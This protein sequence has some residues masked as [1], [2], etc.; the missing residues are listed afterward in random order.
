MGT[1]AP[2]CRSTF[3]ESCLYAAHAYHLGDT[4]SAPLAY[5]P[6]LCAPQGSTL[7]RGDPG[8]PRGTV[9]A[10]GEQVLSS[11]VMGGAGWRRER[12]AGNTRLPTEVKPRQQSIMRDDT[13]LACGA[14]AFGDALLFFSDDS[15]DAFM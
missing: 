2:P 11:N 8:R 12:R 14:A 13:V 6:C 10:G 1:R 5:F 15:P 4:G 3:V 9:F 7:R